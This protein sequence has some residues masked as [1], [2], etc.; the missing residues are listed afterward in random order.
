ML[1]TLPNIEYHKQLYYNFERILVITSRSDSS[2]I[3][4]LTHS[5]LSMKFLTLIWPQAPL[6]QMRG[7]AQFWVALFKVEAMGLLSGGLFSIVNYPETPK[8]DLRKQPDITSEIDE[9]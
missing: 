3:Y 4:I 9:S 7:S 1:G 5:P 6:R 2:I 8:N